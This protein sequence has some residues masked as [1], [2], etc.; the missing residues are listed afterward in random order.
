MQNVHTL[1]ME[2]DVL[3]ASRIVRFMQRW[4]CFQVLCCCDCFD[5][6]TELNRTRNARL[7]NRKEQRSALDEVLK[8]QAAAQQESVSRAIATK[9]D[10]AFNGN[11]EAARAE[12]LAVRVRQKTATDGSEAPPILGY[13]LPDGDREEI[14][15]ETRRQDAYL[16]RIGTTVES[17]RIMSLDLHEELAAQDPQIEVLRDRVHN[18]HDNI[19]TLSKK[20]RKI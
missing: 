15:A 14:Q 12:L 3:E 6:D 11:D 4:C 20:A 1:Q 18:A 10:A 5:P 9:G 17:L 13:G 7:R 19:G 8:R 16:D 2:K